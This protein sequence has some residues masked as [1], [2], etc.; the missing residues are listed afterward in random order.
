LDFPAEPRRLDRIR[1]PRPA[2]QGVPKHQRPALGGLEIGVPVIV[3]RIGK[4]RSVFQVER[5]VRYDYSET[6]VCQVSSATDTTSLRRSGLPPALRF[7]QDGVLVKHV[8]PAVRI[9]I[10]S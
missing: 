7:G 6:R 1:R 3:Q 10:Q 2:G 4:Q 9:L 8:A 5:F